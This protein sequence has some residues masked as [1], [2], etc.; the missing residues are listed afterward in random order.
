MD[1]GI[2]EKLKRLY[3]KLVLRRLLLVEN[4]GNDSVVNFSKTI[5][6]KDA[7][8]TLADALDSLTKHKVMNAWKKL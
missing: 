6:L 5:N 3:R 2:I 7:C 8:F 1:Q 4:E